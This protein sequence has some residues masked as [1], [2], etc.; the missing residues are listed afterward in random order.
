[1]NESDGS[2]WVT[3]A[4]VVRRLAGVSTAAVWLPHVG[5]STV[6]GLGL[7]AYDGGVPDAAS[8]VLMADTAFHQR[9]LTIPEPTI[10]ALPGSSTTVLV[11]PLLAVDRMLGLLTLPV[12]E[13]LGEL[14]CAAEQVLIAAFC[15]RLALACHLMQTER[16]KP[17][18]AVDNDRERIAHDLNDH[19]V[20]QLSRVG[21]ALAGA[22]TQSADP[23][24]QTR[25]EAA[26]DRLD[27]TIRQ[28]RI[29]VFDLHG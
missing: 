1:M 28:I 23:A 5:N 4:R 9:L 25:I 13:G 6:G 24:V 2:P 10:A 29:T 21:L 26:I 18:A 17:K 14:R 19:V 15:G 7:A 20:R 11:V 27:E 22:A 12:E 8:R 3:I 16:V